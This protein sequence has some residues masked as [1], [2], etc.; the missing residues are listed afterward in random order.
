M[1]TIREL[2][3]CVG[4][5]ERRPSTKGITVL[6]F[7]LVQEEQ[8]PPKLKRKGKKKKHCLSNILSPVPPS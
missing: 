8:P 3:H 5:E 6:K 1:K 2:G 7:H 4:S